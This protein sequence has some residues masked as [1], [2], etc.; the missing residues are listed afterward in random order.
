MTL[1]LEIMWTVWVRPRVSRL[2]A[3]MLGILPSPD[4][5]YYACAGG[6]AFPL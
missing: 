3:E 5:D 4:P 1:I 6:A 2:H